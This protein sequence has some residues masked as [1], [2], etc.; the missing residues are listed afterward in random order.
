MT[1][2]R[3]ELKSK[4]DYY[5][6]GQLDLVDQI[7]K[8]VLKLEANVPEGFD[9]ALDILSLLKNIKVRTIK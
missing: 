5:T 7:K 4:E 6:Q 3:K 1:K 8:D 2:E 9:L